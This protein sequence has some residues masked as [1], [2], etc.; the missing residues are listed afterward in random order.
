MILDR[1]QSSWRDEDH[2][3]PDHTE[4]FGHSFPSGSLKQIWTVGQNRLV[5]TVFAL[6][7]M[8]CQ[9]RECKLGKSLLDF[10]L[11]HNLT[12]F[13]TPLSLFTVHWLVFFKAWPHV[14]HSVFYRWLFTIAV[15]TSWSGTWYK[16]QLRDP[17][18]SVQTL[19]S[20]VYGQFLTAVHYTWLM[21]I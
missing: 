11:L 6:S 2:R 7:S 13:L 15:G 21:V 18:W 10:S 17:Y 12:C 3:I 20:Y 19:C 14:R 8:D 1:L 4:Y 16:L 9:G 5:K